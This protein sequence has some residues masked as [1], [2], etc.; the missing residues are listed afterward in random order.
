M[1]LE[2]LDIASLKPFRRALFN[3]LSAPLAEFTFAQIV[4]G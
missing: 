2:D 3:V 1:S 4:D